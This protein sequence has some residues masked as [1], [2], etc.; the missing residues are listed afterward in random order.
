MLDQAIQDSLIGRHGEALTELGQLDLEGV[1]AR[2]DDRR[3]EELEV[4]A[5]V[6]PAARLSG[7]QHSVEHDLGATDVEL[8]CGG[9]ALQQ[10]LDI[11]RRTGFGISVHHEV[12]DQQVLQLGQEGHQ[13]AAATG[14]VHAHRRALGLAARSHADQRRDANAASDQYSPCLT[15]VQRKVILGHFDY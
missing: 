6:G 2:L 3:S 10:R 11:Q 7:G 14:I 4:Y 8:V 13:V 5:V 12:I 15:C 9:V 1:I